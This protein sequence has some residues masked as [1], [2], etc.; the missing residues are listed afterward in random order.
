MMS[1]RSL[2]FSSDQETS[3]QLGQALLELE[4]QVEHCPEIFMA[5]EKLTSHGFEVIA[6]DWD[7]GVEASFLLKTARELKANCNAFTIAIARTQAAPA[8]RYAGANLVITKPVLPGQV[9]Y[10]L[11]SSPDFVARMRSWKPGF[12]PAQ[13]A[14][15]VSPELSHSRNQQSSLYAQPS[16]NSS[17]D[18][19]VPL[20]MPVVSSMDSG[21]TGNYRRSGIQTLFSSTLP[22]PSLAE[23][24][25]RHRLRNFLRGSAFC[26]VLVSAGTFVRVKLQNANPAT[27]AKIEQTATAGEK[28][29]IWMRP[30]PQRL[31]ASRR[32]GLVPPPAASGT[33]QSDAIRIEPMVYYDPL[34]PREVSI[35]LDQDAPLQPLSQ[36]ELVPSEAQTALDSAFPLRDT[37][38]VPPSLK[39]SS[40]LVTVRDSAPRP[41]LSLLSGLEPVSLSEDDSQ[42]MV[43]QKVQPTYPDQ[44]VRTGLQGT[45][46]L[47]ALIGK[48][49]AIQ[50]LKLIRGSFLLGEAAFHAVKQWR[51]RPYFLNGRAVAAQTFVTVDFKLPSV[52]R[53]AEPQR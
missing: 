37:N 23:A 1:P 38:G 49:G 9:R 7:D 14:M 17:N 19:L 35:A 43:V 41:T 25:P 8:A 30:S 29:Q 31:R 12:E 44:A 10:A 27:D 2:L 18:E 42:K 3:R 39:V 13:S 33:M 36:I 45:V 53:A 32:N 28:Q 40:P 34:A 51:Y 47:Q 4:F 6:A 15:A 24:K 48:D 20:S 5:V 16:P 11:L 52:A 26:L 22:E 50:D 21:D 46:V